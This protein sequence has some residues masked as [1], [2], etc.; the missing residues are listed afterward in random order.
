MN[1]YNPPS[2]DS[3]ISLPVSKTGHRLALLGVFLQIFPVIG[4][5]WSIIGVTAA[6]TVLGHSGQDVGALAAILGRY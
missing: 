3:S 1:P 2:P 5:I 4:L 6:K